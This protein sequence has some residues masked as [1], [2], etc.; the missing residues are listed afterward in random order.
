MKHVSEA[1]ICH[2]PSNSE[3][4]KCYPQRQKWQHL[5][6]QLVFRTMKGDDVTSSV[7]DT[8]LTVEIC[9]KCIGDEDKFRQSLSKA[10]RIDGG[11][12]ESGWPRT[13]KRDR[14]DSLDGPNAPSAPC[15]PES[16]V[17]HHCA[18]ERTRR[19]QYT[20]E[21]GSFNCYRLANNQKS[22]KN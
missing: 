1:C 2:G 4:G 17:E 12:T 15:R 18:F 20:D 9:D 6:A 11:G 14:S 19:K 7:F 13:D 16:T 10:D 5:S 8:V 22:T 21:G 3:A